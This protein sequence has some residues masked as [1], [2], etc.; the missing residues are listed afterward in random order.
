MV[1]SISIIRF[2]VAAK[3]QFTFHSLYDT[4]VDVNNVMKTFKGL[5]VGD[6]EG[7]ECSE[8]VLLEQLAE[9]HNTVREEPTAVDMSH[10]VR[11]FA[12]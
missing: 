5:G 3:E 9:H 2:Q 1:L 11:I 10:V 12:I 8:G 7:S 4:E 6:G